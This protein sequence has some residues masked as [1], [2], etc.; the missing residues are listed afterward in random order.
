[1]LAAC[2][3]D[4]VRVEDELD[5]QVGLAGEEGLAYLVVGEQ[6]AGASDE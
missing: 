2:R 4:R 6:V 1:M 5:P 3:G